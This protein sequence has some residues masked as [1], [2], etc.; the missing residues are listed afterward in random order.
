MKQFNI[1]YKDVYRKIIQLDNEFWEGLK[2]VI[3]AYL[4]STQDLTYNVLAYLDRYGLHVCT[5]YL[6]LDSECIVITRY[7]DLINFRIV[8]EHLE[9]E[10]ELGIEPWYLPKIPK[11][12]G[13]VIYYSEDYVIHAYKSYLIVKFH[14][15]RYRFTYSRFESLLRFLEQNGMSFNED[16]I[17]SYKR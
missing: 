6:K 13:K 1:V 4:N 9:N 16:S 5:V 3:N 8:Y 15:K 10:I 11:E 7:K 12:L 2:E 14:N 17:L